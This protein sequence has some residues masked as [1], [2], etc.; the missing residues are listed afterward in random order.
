MQLTAQ[1]KST[2]DSTLRE[3]FTHHRD[4]GFRLREIAAGVGLDATR[5]Y[6]GLRRLQSRGL[7]RYDYSGGW[8]AEDEC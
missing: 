8:W 3:F 2:I 5:I 1:A 4:Q 6:G 7:L